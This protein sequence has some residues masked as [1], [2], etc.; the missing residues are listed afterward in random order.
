MI[1]S[2]S[3]PASVAPTPSAAPALP[4]AIPIAPPPAAA[5]TRDDHPVPPESI[6]DAVPPASDD[7]AKPD[8]HGRSR[9]GKWISAIPLLGPGLTTPGIETSAR[10]PGGARLPQ[11]SAVNKPDEAHFPSTFGANIALG[12]SGLTR[13]R[14]ARKKPPRTAIK[15]PI[16]DTFGTHRR[17]CTTK[18]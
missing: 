4:P 14:K 17:P 3:P 13:Q 11:F 8:E 9:I 12:T 15:R 18:F 1:L 7:V 5:Q 10:L 2:S 6:P 16:P